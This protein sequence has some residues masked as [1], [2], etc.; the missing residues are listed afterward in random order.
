MVSGVPGPGQDVVGMSA[1]QDASRVGVLRSLDL[2]DTPPEER[3]DRITRLAQQLFGVGT[4]GVNLVDRDRQFTKAA[5]GRLP[6]GDMPRED[7]LCTHTVQH[8]D[9]LEIPDAHADPAWSE[10]PTVVGDLGLRFYAGVPLRAPTGE[11]V[12]ALCLIDSE[13]RTL[14]DGEQELLRGLGDLVERELASSADLEGAREVQRR[15]LPR[16]PPR[17]EGWEVAGASVQM[18]AV[19]GDFYDWQVVDGALQLMLCDVMGKGMSA[20]L[21][22]AGV[23]VVA[24]AATPH[25]TL[26]STV[27]RM[28]DDL[29]GDLEETGSFVTAFATRVSPD[30]GRLEYVDAGHG[31]AFVLEPGGGFRRLQSAG[32]PIG[33]LPDETWTPSQE[34]VAPGECLVVVSDGLLD[35]HEDVPALVAS[36]RTL[37]EVTGTADELAHAIARS[38]GRSTSDDVTVVL[39][40]REALR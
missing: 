39:A 19:G 6:L 21:V 3:F 4:A 26:A 32:L 37:T 40:R 7:S 12:G 30:D 33:A 11:R 14:S 2:L 27:Q 16:H 22:A 28:A 29:A 31:L 15:L 20:A 5:V 10:H 35:V 17:L 8:D 36:I 18:G 13:P 38:G 25:H 23:R 24:R 9:I 34:V 1:A